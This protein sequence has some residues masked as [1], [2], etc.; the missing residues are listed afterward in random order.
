MDKFTVFE[1]NFNDDE[2]EKAF[3]EFFYKNNLSALFT[4]EHRSSPIKVGWIDAKA[5]VN[6]KGGYVKALKELSDILSMG[7][8]NK[9]YEQGVLKIIY[10]PNNFSHMMKIIKRI[11]TEYETT[12]EKHLFNFWNIVFYTK[13]LF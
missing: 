12:E 7:T 8:D 4:N 10:V 2:L 5:V 13:Q 3:H 9:K 1:M 11:I 6:E